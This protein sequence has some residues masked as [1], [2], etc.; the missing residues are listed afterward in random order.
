MAAAET[1]TA[2]SWARGRRRAAASC[3]PTSPAC[4]CPP[5]PT[6]S[7]AWQRVTS[8]TA[9]AAPTP[10]AAAPR[11]LTPPLQLRLPAASMTGDAGMPKRWVGPTARYHCRGPRAVPAACRTPAVRTLQVDTQLIRAAAAPLMRWRQTRQVQ[12]VAAAACALM[13]ALAGLMHAGAGCGG[14][15]RLR[16]RATASGCATWWVGAWDQLGCLWGG[17]GVGGRWVMG[18]GARRVATE[19]MKGEQVQCQAQ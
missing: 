2:R 13:A 8:T 1:L 3:P 19:G 7:K 15:R 11:A 16:T 12:L 6:R 9:A 10:T 18:V 14:W 4:L 5:P 17:S